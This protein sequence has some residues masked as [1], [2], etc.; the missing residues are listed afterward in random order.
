MFTG[1]YQE[2]ELSSKI[3]ASS[4]N[5]VTHFQASSFYVEGNPE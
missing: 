5:W 2:A 1:S 3:A 4:Q